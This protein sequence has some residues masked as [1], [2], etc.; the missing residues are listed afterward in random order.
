MHGLQI[1]INTGEKKLCNIIYTQVQAR[2]SLQA[3]PCV[4][5]KDP[6]QEGLPLKPNLFICKEEHMLKSG[7]SNQDS[8]SEGKRQQKNQ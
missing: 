6:V 2:Y 3:R 5:T 1:M 7:P 4:L 8:E